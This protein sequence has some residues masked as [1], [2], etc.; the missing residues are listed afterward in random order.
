[1]NLKKKSC[2]VKVCKRMIFLWGGM[3]VPDHEVRSW[4]GLQGRT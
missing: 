2:D 4:N 1:M 3:G